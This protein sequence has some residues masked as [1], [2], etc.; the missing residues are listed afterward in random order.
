M[1]HKPDQVITL[2]TNA[3]RDHATIVFVNPTP[4]SVTITN[5]AQ[6]TTVAGYNWFDACRFSAELLNGQAFGL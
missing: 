5:D 6:F 3:Y 4:E 2:Q 1:S